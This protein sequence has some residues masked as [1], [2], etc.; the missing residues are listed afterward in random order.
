M[1][2]KDCP[3][4]LYLYMQIPVNV[5]YTIVPYTMWL[6]YQLIHEGRM[7]REVD[8]GESMAIILGP[9]GRTLVTR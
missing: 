9:V 8:H 4:I 1:W 6:R 2:R 7:V 5:P 3:D